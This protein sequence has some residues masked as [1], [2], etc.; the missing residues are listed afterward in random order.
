MSRLLDCIRSSKSKP[1]PRAS[2]RSAKD[3]YEETHHIPRLPSQRRALT[4]AS[5]HQKP[6]PQ[7]QSL[8]F[9]FIPRDL[10]ISIYDH[11][12]TNLTIHVEYSYSPEPE[13]DHGLRRWR[14]WSSV[15]HDDTHFHDFYEDCC[16]RQELSLR[17]KE[18]RDK[19]LSAE[20]RVAKDHADM[21]R[22]ARWRKWKIGVLGWLL[23]CR[24]W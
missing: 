21:K 16:K 17:W 12:F 22:E 18:P 4:Q 11:I 15:C 6:N 23:A 20:E 10:R 9:N 13:L 3:K 8:F 7:A 2:N 1:K 19:K 5:S 14:W 24:L